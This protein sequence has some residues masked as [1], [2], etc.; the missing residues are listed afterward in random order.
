MKLMTKL[1][2]YGTLQPKG[3]LHSMLKTVTESYEPATL[4]NYALYKPPLGLY[5]EVTKDVNR[6]VKG[7]LMN[8]QTNTENFVEVLMMELFAGYNAEVLE[9]RTE[10][11]LLINALTF[12]A[13]RTPKG[14]LIESGD[15]LAYEKSLAFNLQI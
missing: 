12:V 15:W 4:N 10:H 11:G 13:N 3:S 5:P 9:V 2:V 1:F 8:V 14:F 6:K 7:C